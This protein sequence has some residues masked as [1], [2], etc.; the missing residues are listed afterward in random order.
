MDAGLIVAGGTDAPVCTVNP[1]YG[2]ECA[3]T[4]QAVGRDD[5]TLG[6]DQAISVYRAVEMV[7]KNAAYWCSEE[8]RKGR[9][10]VHV[11]FPP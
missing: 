8:H 7:T 3:V 4:R 11:L 10:L 5:V 9:F 1:F 6:A 2:V